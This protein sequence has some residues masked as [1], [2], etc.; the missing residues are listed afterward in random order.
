MTNHQTF[1]LLAI[2][3]LY[4]TSSSSSNSSSSSDEEIEILTG[5]VQT[6]QTL[7]GSKFKKKKREKRAKSTVWFTNICM[8]WQNEEFRRH[9]RL[10]RDTFEWILREISPETT[11][12]HGIS[13]HLKL[14]AT[15]WFLATGES[16]RAIAQ[17][18]GIGVSTFHYHFRNTIQLIINI[19][20]KEKIR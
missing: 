6:F 15:L 18:F 3:T 1:F 20:L 13:M 9:F 12:N 5:V 17:R 4:E 14:A 7:N 8:Q 19:F 11:E 10:G 16:F 2:D